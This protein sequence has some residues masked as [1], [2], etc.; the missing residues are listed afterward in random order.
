MK[1]RDIRLLIQG[2]ALKDQLLE[3]NHQGLNLDFVV[4]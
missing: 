2:H 1:L 3:S 4:S